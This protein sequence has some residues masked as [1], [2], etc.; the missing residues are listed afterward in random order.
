MENGPLMNDLPIKMG[1]SIAMLV[2]A[3][4]YLKR[5]FRATCLQNR[6][7]LEMVGNPIPNGTIQFSGVSY[8]PAV[9]IDP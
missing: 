9:V 6:L 8:E 2:I 1:G 3:R 4:G 5:C 7:V